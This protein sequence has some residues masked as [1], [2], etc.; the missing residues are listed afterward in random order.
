MCAKKLGGAASIMYEMGLSSADRPYSLDGRLLGLS[1]LLVLILVGTI[2]L[3]LYARS[4]DERAEITERLRQELNSKWNCGP[5]PSATPA[6]AAIS[7]DQHP[8]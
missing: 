2:E 1:A 7:P 3:L 5:V 4:E 6:P 8:A